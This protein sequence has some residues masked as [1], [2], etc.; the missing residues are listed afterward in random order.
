MMTG[1]VRKAAGFAVAA[2]ALSV[3][4]AIAASSPAQAEQASPEGSS[5]AGQS[6]AGCPSGAVCI[7]PK[8]SWNGGKPEHVYWSY[9]AHKLYNEYGKHRVFNNQYGGATMRVCKG[10]GGTSCGSKLIPWRYMDVNLT[11]INSIRL[12]R[13]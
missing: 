5:T 13:S 12:D 9:G 8:A 10:S 11:P 6:Y 2:T 1:H 7:Y 3:T 4:G